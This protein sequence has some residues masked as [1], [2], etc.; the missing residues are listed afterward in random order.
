[1]TSCRF[2]GQ[3]ST[4][5]GYHLWNSDAEHQAPSTSPVRAAAKGNSGSA[6]PWDSTPTAIE[7]STNVRTIFNGY[8][9]GYFQ[10][11]RLAKEVG[12]RSS[13]LQ[14]SVHLMKTYIAL[15]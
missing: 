9:G 15:I 4:A 7:T 2:C 5:A 13:S 6:V 1:V 10:T 12:F 14:S 3:R 11:E 8:C